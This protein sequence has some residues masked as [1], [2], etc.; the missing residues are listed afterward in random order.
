MFP[1]ID[2]A[3][4]REERENFTGDSVEYNNTGSP[5]LVDSAPES[6][7]KNNSPP[8]TRGNLRGSSNQNVTSNSV[9]ARDL[10]KEKDNM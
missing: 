9:E 2:I 3:K 1:K 10:A 8:T 7:D 4:E 6:P 5:P